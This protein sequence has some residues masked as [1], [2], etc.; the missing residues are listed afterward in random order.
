MSDISLLSIYKQDPNIVCREIAGEMIL[1]P[2]RSNVSDMASIY[3]L[4][5]TAAVIWQQ[6]DGQRTL[7]EIKGVI[8]N[9]FDVPPD[10]AE[11]DLFE[12]VENLAGV[13]A[14]VSVS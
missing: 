9:Q 1:V 5:E 8:I 12:L 13:G 14:L 6:I 11:Q 7:E 3:T 4:N 10:Q 2:I